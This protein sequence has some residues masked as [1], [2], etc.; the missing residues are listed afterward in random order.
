MDDLLKQQFQI[1][2]GINGVST[3]KYNVTWKNMRYAITMLETVHSEDAQCI[4]RDLKRYLNK[5]GFAKFTDQYVITDPSKVKSYNDDRNLEY[6]GEEYDFDYSRKD[7]SGLTVK[8]A[9]LGNILD[10]QTG[11]VEVSEDRMSVIL[12]HKSENNQDG[13]D[14]GATVKSPGSGT[15]IARNDGT[16]KI[17]L[18]TSGAEGKTITIT[19]FQ[20]DSSIQ[21]GTKVSKGQK[22]GVTGDG[23]IV[24]TMEDENGKAISPVGYLPVVSASSADLE[25]MARIMQGEAESTDPDG[26]AAVGWCIMHRVSTAGFPDTLEGVIYQDG[27]FTGVGT[28]NFN[29]DIT[30]LVYN[31]ARGVLSETL[32]D[33]VAAKNVLPGPS[34]YFQAED[35]YNDYDWATYPLVNIGGNVFSAKWYWGG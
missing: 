24:V 7:G 9:P 20:V 30:P 22:I 31:V 33:P 32:E 4:V 6:G 18:T 1:A 3:E 27:Q 2:D 16:V 34:L 35:N 11:G 23:D 12:H 17:K 10:N 14:T 21:T 25:L 29:K 15:V 8:Q 13:F 19:G 26:M 28:A 5:R